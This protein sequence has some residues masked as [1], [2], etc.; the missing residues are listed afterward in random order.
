MGHAGADS[1][2]FLSPYRHQGLQGARLGMG[3]EE[4]EVSKAEN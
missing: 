4:R 3:V 2:I 1:E